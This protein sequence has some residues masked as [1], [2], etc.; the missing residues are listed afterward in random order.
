MN[1]RRQQLLEYYRYCKCDDNILK[2]IKLYNLN[3]NVI[4]QEYFF[5]LQAESHNI[6]EE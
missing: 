1:S 2:F 4:E 6:K 5:G 3:Y